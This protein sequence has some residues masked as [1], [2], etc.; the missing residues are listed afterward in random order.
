MVDFKLHKLTI[1]TLGEYLLAVRKD[2][3]LT[4]LEVAT[5]IGTTVKFLDALEA[6]EFGHLPE[7]VYV[8]GFIRKLAVLY[9]I[10]APALVAQFN[11]EIILAKDASTDT[12]GRGWKTLAERLVPRRV[13]LLFSL[14]LGAVFVLVCVW[15]IFSIGKVPSLTV[16][17]PRLGAKV[18]SGLVN[19]S[20]TATPG[21]EIAVN[22][23]KVFAGADGE[24]SSAVSFLSGTQTLV[25]SAKSRFGKIATKTINFVVE[26]AHMNSPVGPSGL[27]GASQSGVTSSFAKTSMQVAQ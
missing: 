6:G 17:E 11:R 22:G 26:D 4:Q 8:I 27:K 16:A 21:S 14:L 3:G 25:V 9:K 20:G 15:Q 18:I 24:F 5:R 13:G 1:E 23:H 7:P 19:V 12:T 10:E 2:T